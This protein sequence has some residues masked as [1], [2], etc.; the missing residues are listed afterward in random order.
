QNGLNPYEY[1][2]KIFTKAPLMNCREDWY[3]LLAWNIHLD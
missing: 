1:L 2:R 3:R